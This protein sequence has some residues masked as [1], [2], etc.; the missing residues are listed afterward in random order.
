MAFHCQAT[1]QRAVC[2]QEEHPLVQSLLGWVRWV[3]AGTWIPL[4][5]QLDSPNRMIAV[6]FFDLDPRME[7]NLLLLINI[8]RTN[9]TEY[10]TYIEKHPVT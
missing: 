10:S 9:R 4:E 1:E 5:D 7:L 2:I 6:E 3:D 8:I